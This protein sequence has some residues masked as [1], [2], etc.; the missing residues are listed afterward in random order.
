MSGS[1][2]CCQMLCGL[3]EQGGVGRVWRG[4]R[5]AL[6]AT[7]VAGRWCCEGGLEAQA[8]V[9]G[10][11]LGVRERDQGLGGCLG[12]CLGGFKGVEGTGFQVGSMR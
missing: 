5:S 10:L 12:G 8:R 7:L 2:S 1:A 4:S 3:V 11:D 9:W 6:S